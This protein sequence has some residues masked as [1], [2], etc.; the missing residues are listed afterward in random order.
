MRW[1]G[2]GGREEENR[3]ERRYEGREKKG[4][5]RRIHMPVVLVGKAECEEEELAEERRALP[6]VAV[7]GV[8]PVR[9]EKKVSE[10]ESD[11]S[12]CCMMLSISEMTCFA[13]EM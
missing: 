4:Q 5:Q 2:K 3:G 6:P 10:S 12:S 11:C 7:V 9:E 13:R 1:G 8:V